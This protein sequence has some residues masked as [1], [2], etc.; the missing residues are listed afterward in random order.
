MAKEVE[1]YT[2]TVYENG[3][4]TDYSIMKLFE[5][6]E[7]EIFD[8]KNKA[9]KTRTLDGS[10]IRIFSYYRTMGKSQV[11]IPFGK[12]KIGNRPYAAD[13]EDNLEL[14]RGDLYDVNALGYDND[15]KVM[16]FTTLRNGPSIKNIEDYLNSC[17]SSNNGITIRIEPIKYNTGIENVRKAELVRSVTFNLDLGQSLNAF[18][19]DEIESNRSKTLVDSFKNFANT[20]KTVGDSRRLDITIGLGNTKRDDTLNK[21]SIMYLLDQINIQSGFVKEI[22]I[23]YKNGASEKMDFAKL[24]DS[25][26]MLSYTC[27]CKESQVT[28]QELLNNFDSAIENKMKYITRHIR[29][30]YTDT[31]QY[32]GD[33]LII[34]ATYKNASL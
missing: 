29:E 23:N 5:N 32:S 30:F 19:N 6:I 9:D 16:A 7:S 20:V 34:E 18:Y 21:D 22:S 13:D 31:K 15:Y 1:F 12:E 24:K 33:I 11:V 2:I 17:I 10:K 27:N 26:F 25:N 4:K 14:V 28:P 3:E 8:K